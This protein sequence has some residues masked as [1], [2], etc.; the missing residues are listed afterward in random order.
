MNKIMKR[1]RGYESGQA[2]LLALIL[3]GV[4]SLVL[5]PL[6]GFMS[7]GLSAGVIHEDKMDELYACDA[8]VQDAIWKINNRDEVPGFPESWDA[9]PN[10][11]E[12]SIP[13]VNGNLVTVNLKY[14]NPENGGTFRVRS[15]VGGTIVDNDTMIDAIIATLF[16][17]D[18]SGIMDNVVTSQGGYNLWPGTSVTPPDGENGPDG[19]YQGDWPRPLEIAL[20]YW[21]DVYT[22]DSYDSDTLYVEDEEYQPPP[23]EDGL[24]PLYSDGTIGDGTLSIINTGTAGL[25]LRLNGTLYITGDTLIGTTNKDFTLDLNGNSIFVESA[26]GVDPD[27]GEIVPS[28][29]ALEIGG[30]CT[31]TGSGCIIAVGSIKFEPNMD[32]SSDDYILILSIIGTTLMQPNGDFYGTLAGKA[33]VDIRNG[34]AYWTDPD[35]V[36]G[37]I[38]FPGGGSEE[39]LHWGIFTWEIS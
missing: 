22:L 28:K 38:N 2:L 35:N 33:S 6:L 37:G 18:Y 23:A 21:Y 32:S 9:N 27:T 20:Y 15:W 12:Y 1:L 8:G 29:Y 4:G 31:L 39:G 11:I 19:D 14:I 16:G 34:D 7:S 13:D 30:K 36:D 5:A 3:L 25:T 10:Y 17:G 24:G 26:T